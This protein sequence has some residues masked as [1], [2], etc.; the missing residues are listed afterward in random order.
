MESR[1]EIQV[2]AKVYNA[3]GA[4]GS[5]TVNLLINGATEQS[6]GVGV[7]PGTSQTV[8]FTVYRT[9]AREYQVRL[10]D[11]VGTF[12]VMEEEDAQAPGTGGLLVGGELDSGGIIAIILIAIIVVGGIVVAILLGRPRAT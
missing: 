2:S 9:E 6:I 1:Q 12:Y 3:G 5:A 10:L 4:W 8:S 11:A 7:A